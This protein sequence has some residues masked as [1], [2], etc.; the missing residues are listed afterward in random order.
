YHA[1]G[2]MADH[3]ALAILP[4]LRELQ[5]LVRGLRS[6]LVLRANEMVGIQARQGRHKK[7]IVP[8]PD[9]QLARMGKSHS[10]LY[11]GR[12]PGHAQDATVL[13]AEIELHQVA[14]AALRQPL[15]ELERAAQMGVGLEIR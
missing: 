3:L 15:G 7:S 2:S 11:R 13:H 4:R 12:T 14:L 10:G 9:A 8:G 6:L 5:Q 1:D